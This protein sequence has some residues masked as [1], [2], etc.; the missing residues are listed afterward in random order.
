M[1]TRDQGR[2]VEIS[3]LNSLILAFA[4]PK[5]IP[6]VLAPT[7][8]TQATDHF[9]KEE[10]LLTLT[11]DSITRVSCM[12]RTVERSFGVGAVAI[13]VAVVTVFVAFITICV[14]PDKIKCMGLHVQ[15]RT[16]YLVINK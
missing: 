8:S 3:V 15:F 11:R 13:C 14:K 12:T 2:V 1:V 10:P 9:F 6:K 5:I 4:S 16:V 7:F